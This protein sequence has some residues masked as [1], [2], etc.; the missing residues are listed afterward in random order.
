GVEV[1][2]VLAE[3]DKQL[4]PEDRGGNRDPIA[5]WL[6]D[7][8]DVRDD[9]VPLEA[10]PSVAVPAEPGLYFV[11]DVE[12][13]RLVHLVYHWLE[14]AAGVRVHPVG[15]EDAVGDEG[16]QPGPMPFQ[17]RNRRTDLAAYVFAKGLPGRDPRFVGS[18]YGAD[19]SAQGGAF[20]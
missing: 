3:L 6:A 2:Y 9:F 7:C 14:E 1:P 4:G 16:A 10:P 13:A 19:V 15:G 11:G 8:H 17:V 18:V 20:P 12:P 5:H